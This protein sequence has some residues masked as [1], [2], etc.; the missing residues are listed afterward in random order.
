MKLKTEEQNLFDSVEEGLIG[1]KKMEALIKH[2]QLASLFEDDFFKSLDRFGQAD[3]IS[4]CI[5]NKIAQLDRIC[6]TL[7]Q[8]Q[9]TY[10]TGVKVNQLAQRLV[11]AKIRYLSSMADETSP[12]AQ[13]GQ[14]SDQKQRF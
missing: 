10:P 1:P 5:N 8:H 12:V 11:K 14:S 13:I 7:M 2:G 4:A 3:A 6:S 9:Q